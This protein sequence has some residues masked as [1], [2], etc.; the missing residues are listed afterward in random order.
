MAS[1]LYNLLILALVMGFLGCESKNSYDIQS[2]QAVADL[3]TRIKSLEEDLNGL[4]E[5]LAQVRK[6]LDDP[7]I[8]AELRGSIRKEIHEGDKHLHEIEQWI[9]F[10]KI[11]RKKRYN[12]LVDRQN[13]PKLKEQA[14]K[15]V[16]DYFM[17]KKLNPIQRG[18]KNR[19][20][21]AIE[22]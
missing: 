12:S 17:D 16:K 10:L 3:S 19:Y 9:A 20:R 1:F 21:T 18:W 6:V 11:R 14:E 5:E 13:S 2:D 4:T 8:D 15:E 7:D 22:L